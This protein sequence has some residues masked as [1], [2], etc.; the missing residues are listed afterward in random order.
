MAF[1]PDRGFTLLNF[2]F[3]FFIALAFGLYLESNYLVTFYADWERSYFVRL[4]HLA[5]LG[6]GSL[7]FFLDKEEI[8]DDYLLQFCRPEQV[9]EN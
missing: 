2:F 1:L 4:F 7:Y 6:C 8:F 3:L 5:F 9:S